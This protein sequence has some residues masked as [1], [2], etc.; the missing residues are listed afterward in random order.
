[1]SMNS[2]A[3][4]L[5]VPVRREGLCCV[6]FLLCAL[7]C[8]V[9][10]RSLSSCLRR[11]S[12]GWD[13]PDVTRRSHSTPSVSVG[14]ILEHDCK[15][16]YLDLFDCISVL[17]AVRECYLICLLVEQQQQQQWQKQQH[18]QHTN[19]KNSLC[20]KLARSCCSNKDYLHPMLAPRFNMCLK[21]RDYNFTST[22]VTYLV[23]EWISGYY[24]LPVS[25]SGS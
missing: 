20:C 7:P 19:K 17:S 25:V 13:E 1:M 3:V 16:L 2:C 21:S 14:V 22:C 4:S 15:F 24:N 11:A 9:W 12:W 18:E 5:C 8:P 10:L 23:V 6:D